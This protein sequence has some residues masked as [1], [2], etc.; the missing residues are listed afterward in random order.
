[1]TKVKEVSEEEI[2]SGEDVIQLSQV[3]LSHEEFKELIKKTLE[4]GDFEASFILTL[5]KWHRP[6]SSFSDYGRFQ[7]LYGEIEAIEINNYYDYPTT[8]EAVYA[9]IPKTKAVV[10]LHESGDDYQ[11]KFQKYAKLYIF[12]YAIGWKSID[13][14]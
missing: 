13:L 12:N 9:I 11:G 10:I 5:S 2:K 3:Q 8:N 7:V 14:Y 1:M 6:G 4:K